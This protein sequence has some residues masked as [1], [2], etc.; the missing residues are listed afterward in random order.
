MFSSDYDRM[1]IPDD[2]VYCVSEAMDE[3]E[4][5]AI[6]IKHDKQR[7]TYM[8]FQLFSSTCLISFF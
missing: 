8:Y 6:A 3:I 7:Y 4:A 2:Q 1:V 5:I